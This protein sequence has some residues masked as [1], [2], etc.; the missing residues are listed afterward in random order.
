MNISSRS[1][2]CFLN[3]V[4]VLTMDDDG[5][6]KLY[7]LWTFKEY[8][9]NGTG[10]LLPDAFTCFHHAQEVEGVACREKDAIA[11]WCSMP[12][13]AK[14]MTCDFE[15]LSPYVGHE[16]VLLFFC[17]CCSHYVQ[18]LCQTHLANIVQNSIHSKCLRCHGENKIQ[19]F[20]GWNVS[21][22]NLTCTT[23]LLTRNQVCSAPR[24][25]TCLKFASLRREGRA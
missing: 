9:E 4:Q 22:S 15:I 16:A 8:G 14:V 25:F 11:A 6:K 19:P 20:T 23:H 1:P 13:K 24:F 2:L 18:T 17:I 12:G 5:E 10:A 3:P 21:Q 7:G